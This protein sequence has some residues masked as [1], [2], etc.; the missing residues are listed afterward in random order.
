MTRPAVAVHQEVVCFSEVL[1]FAVADV[2]MRAAS[3]V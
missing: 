2:R 1:F 3:L